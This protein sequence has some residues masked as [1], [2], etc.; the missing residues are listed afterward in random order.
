MNAGTN[1]PLPRAAAEA[2]IAEQLVDLA[3]GRGGEPYFSRALRLRDEV[4]AKLAGLFG[5]GPMQV[6]LRGAS[7]RCSTD[8]CNIV[9]AGL[10]LGRDD[11][12][13]TT[14]VEH[15]G[16]IGPLHASG[17]RIVAAPEDGILDAVTERTRLIAISHV[18]WVT[19]N[20]LDPARIKA[21]TG[22]PVLV[23]GAQSA[24]VIQGGGGGGVY[25][26]LSSQKWVCGAG[27]GGA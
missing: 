12:I 25:Y 1:G 6:A 10:D 21:E 15:F 9:L 20:S 3:E 23:D 24:G 7:A 11:E 17:A 2:M 16:L 5:V 18:S 8:G 4:R 27:R 14:D 19:G 13:V 26:P 22:L